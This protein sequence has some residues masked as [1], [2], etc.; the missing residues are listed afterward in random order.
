MKNKKLITWLLIVLLLSCF[1]FFLRT[2]LVNKYNE[3]V[4]ARNLK[5]NMEKATDVMGKYIT[6][7]YHGNVVMGELRKGYKGRVYTAPI[8]APEKKD[9]QFYHGEL[10]LE[11]KLFNYKIS[12]SYWR[13]ENRKKNKEY[14]LPK[15]T[16]LFGENITVLIETCLIT[17]GEKGSTTDRD[18]LLAEYVNGKKEITEDQIMEVE[19]RLYVFDLIENAREKRE[20]QE[21][22]FALVNFLKE[23]G[24]F[25]YAEISIN[26]MNKC[27]F[28]PSCKAFGRYMTLCPVEKE[29]LDDGSYIFRPG[30]KYR[31]IATEKLVKEISAFTEDELRYKTQNLSEDY[32]KYFDTDSDNT[33]YY[34]SIRSLGML[35]RAYYRIYSDIEEAGELD[36]YDYNELSKINIRKNL[37]YMYDDA[38][39]TEMGF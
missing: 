15:L 38:L 7:K 36:K 29:Y 18:V 10:E 24:L 31:R 2:P 39:Y 28:A 5:D 14:F 32:L 1:M 8:Y 26:F 16:R 9:D 19:L 4:C 22:I 3:L 17:D 37:R 6:E 11:A 30:K 20:Y 12:D 33:Q 13:V 25:E 34:C 23:K 21:R 35:E 27:L